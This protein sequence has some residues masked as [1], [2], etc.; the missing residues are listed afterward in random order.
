MALAIR[1]KF[2][3]CLVA[4]VPTALIVAAMGAC[5]AGPDISKDPA[6]ATA[7]A[8]DSIQPT[9]TTAVAFHDTWRKIWEDHIG[10]T[11]NVI[12]GILD[13]LP[14][15][16]A[17]VTR[18]LQNYE[19]MENLLRPYYGDEADV[20]GDLLEEHLTIAAEIVTALR[21]G[22]TSDV[23][24]LIVEWRANGDELAVQMNKMNPQ[25]WPLASTRAMWQTHLTVTLQEATT[26]FL[27]QCDDEVAAWEQVHLG[28][29]MMA[30]LF[31]GGVIKQFP[32]GFTAN[33]CLK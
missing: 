12:I 9:G 1:S 24:S 32:S 31:S 20:L 7:A 6:D 17:Y 18:L 33:G 19:D 26:H 11:R 23:A 30:D 13:G 10:W 27:H 14:C 25:S 3:L 15:T 2:R 28:G 21:D 5:D 4:F 8:K 22:R 29:L 16:D